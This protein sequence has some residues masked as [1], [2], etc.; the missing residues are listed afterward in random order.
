MADKEN[1]EIYTAVQLIL[2]LN[3]LIVPSETTVSF[4]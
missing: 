4:T 2:S 3:K 1:R